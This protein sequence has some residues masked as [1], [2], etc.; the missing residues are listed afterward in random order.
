[1]CNIHN[2]GCVASDGGGTIVHGEVEARN[3][4]LKQ[5]TGIEAE[6]SADDVMTF[7]GDVRVPALRP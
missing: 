6:Y 2:R 5:A 7:F 4:A 3:A 1:M